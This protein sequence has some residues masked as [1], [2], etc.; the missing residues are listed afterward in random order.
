M[1]HG[2]VSLSGQ[3]PKVGEAVL[4]LGYTQIEVRPIGGDGISLTQV[5][6]ATKGTI[7][8]VLPTGRGDFII[9]YPVA[10]GDFPAPGALSGGPVISSRTGKVFGAVTRSMAPFEEQTRWTSYVSLLSPAFDLPFGAVV[11]GV[12]RDYTIRELARVGI[13]LSD[14]SF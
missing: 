7:E 14:G 13:V 5:L 11:D 4:A 3:L 6:T 9:S 1:R 8:E 2:A 10:R 12:E